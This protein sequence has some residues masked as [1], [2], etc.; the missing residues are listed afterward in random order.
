MAA[1]LRLG[2][3]GGIGSG[4][5]T[6]AHL[7]SLQG[8][9]IIDADAISRSVTAG[10]GAAIAPI[11]AQFG[12]DFINAEGALD[13]DRMRALVY[14]D[15]SARKRLEAIVHPL[16]GREV[17]QQSEVAIRTGCGCVVFDVPLLVESGRWRQRV[18]RVLVVDCT[19][20][21][22]IER[23][24]A[25]DGLARDA[26]EKIMA[27]QAPREIRLRAADAVV[28]NDHLDLDQ[29]AHKVKQFGQRLGLSSRQPAT[30]SRPTIN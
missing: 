4:K 10:G 19:P 6:V 29:L 3:T 14:A 26:V 11:A 5:S 22:Q 30:A 20:D 23:V 25:R 21:V 2:L 27:S 1:P 24:M 9:A 7:L 18:D 15:S 16:V 12:S 28:F 8:A 13:R 17:E